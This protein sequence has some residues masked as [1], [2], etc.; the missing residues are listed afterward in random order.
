[1]YLRAKAM[2]SFNLNSFPVFIEVAEK[3]S[4]TLAAKSLGMT[5]PGVSQHISNLEGDIGTKLFI[6][7]NKKLILTND[8]SSLLLRVLLRL[9]FQSNSE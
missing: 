1:M 9:E 3:A 4:M 7:K 5:Q 6:R 2:I 8:G